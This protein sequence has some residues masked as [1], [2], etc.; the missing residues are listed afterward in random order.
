MFWW[1]FLL[2]LVRKQR[3][4]SPHRVRK[5]NSRLAA[6][7]LAEIEGFF[8]RVNPRRRLKI[9]DVNRNRT[10]YM[11]YDENSRILSTENYILSNN[12]RPIGDLYEDENCTID[13]DDDFYH[14][15]EE[16]G[17]SYSFFFLILIHYGFCINWTNCN[18]LRRTG[19]FGKQI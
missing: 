17:Y 3:L 14:F 16:E 15:L 2:H 6:G 19:I 4:I 9:R 11:A 8:L 18:E 1:K 7:K 10:D 12:K 13:L 5:W